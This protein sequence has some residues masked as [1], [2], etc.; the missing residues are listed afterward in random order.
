LG[1][2]QASIAMPLSYGESTRPS[3]TSGNLADVQY[4]CLIPEIDVCWEPIVLDQGDAW[5]D[6]PKRATGGMQ[7]G[8][9]EFR[10][11]FN[12]ERRVLP[13]E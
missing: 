1:G 11:I 12:V 2:P 3:A 10:T 13:R 6:H 9:H 5:P 8:N 7:R 4:R